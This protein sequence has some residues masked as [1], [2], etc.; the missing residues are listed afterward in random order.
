[1]TEGD[2][3][4]LGAP[5]TAWDIMELLIA[6]SSTCLI[7]DNCLDMVSKYRWRIQRASSSCIYATTNYLRDG[8]K[9]SIQMHRLILGVIDKKV[10]VDHIDGNGLNNMVSNLRICTHSD[11]MKNRKLH[12]SSKSGIKGIRIEKQGNGY[13]A[14]RAC[15]TNNGVKHRKWFNL[16]NMNDAMVWV[17]NKRIELHGEFAY[18]NGKGKYA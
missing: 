3:A 7:D 16:L 17:R 15:V 5:G 4:R 6:K 14:I 8:V 12:S 1:M 10:H 13:D 11:N 18:E 9:T 2:P